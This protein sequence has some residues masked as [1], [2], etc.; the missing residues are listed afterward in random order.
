MNRRKYEHKTGAFT[1][2][3]GKV[4]SIFGKKLKPLPVLKGDMFK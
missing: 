3:N 1:Q 4:S 2:R